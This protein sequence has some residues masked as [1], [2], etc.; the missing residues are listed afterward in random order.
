MYLSTSQTTTPIIRRVC[1]G[2]CGI[3]LQPVSGS[4]RRAPCRF[5]RTR[6]RASPTAGI[7]SFRTLRRAGQRWHYSLRCPTSQ[8]PLLLIGEV[9]LQADDDLR[10]AL[11]QIFIERVDDV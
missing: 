10:E 4:H 9:L 11:V 3:N 7:N 2:C 8:G 1:I 5:S 6:S